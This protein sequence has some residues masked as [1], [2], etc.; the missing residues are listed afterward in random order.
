VPLVFEP[1]R[2]RGHLLVDGG[3]SNPLPGKIL[4]KAG[5]D[6]VI[7]VNL[8]HKDEFVSRRFNMANVIMRSTRIALHNL[9][10]RDAIDCGILVR[11][12]IAQFITPL[13]I[14]KYFSAHNAKEMADIGE[15]AMDNKIAAIKKI[16]NS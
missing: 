2:Y 14:K 1:A 13:G 12:N 5:A 4:K 7:G 16:I 11:P 10:E 6:L 15:K 9:S 3:L 8:Y